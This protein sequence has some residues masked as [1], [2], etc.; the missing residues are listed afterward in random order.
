VLAVLR[1]AHAARAPRV[2]LGLRAHDPLPEWV[3][4]VAAP[5]GSHVWTGP[6]DVWEERAAAAAE[7]THARAAPPAARRESTGEVLVDMQNVNVAYGERRVRFCPP[8]CVY[9]RTSS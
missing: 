4:H 8:D 3:T 7:P 2:L 6:R 5:T 1:A 9:A